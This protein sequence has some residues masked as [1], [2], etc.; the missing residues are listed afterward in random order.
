MPSVRL[1][2][3][4][5]AAR[6]RCPALRTLLLTLRRL[7]AELLRAFRTRGHAPRVERAIAGYS[8]LGEHSRIWF[9]VAATGALGRG[10]GRAVYLRALRTLVAAE[11]VAA[12]LKRVVRR[13]RPR[14]DRLPALATVPSDL[15]YPSAHA[16]T[17]F[18]AAR[19]L[20]GVLPA[21]PL[22]CA[23]IVMAGTRPY[24]GVHYPSDAVAGVF[25][26]VAL[27]ELVP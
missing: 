4:R 25:L 20:A 7:D 5:A 27:A 15:S 10:D 19:V 14:L 26:G 6:G 16:A 11:V 8:R 23:A 3:E 18:A 24:L 21:T 2:A 1:G 12:A 13:T 9:G 22:Y 17:S